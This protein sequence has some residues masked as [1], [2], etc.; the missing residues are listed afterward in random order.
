M[1][2]AKVHP[3][4]PEDGDRRKTR[5][6]FSEDV[7]GKT[8]EGKDKKLYVIR[9]QTLFAEYGGQRHPKIE[10]F[11]VHKKKGNL[12]HWR[13]VPPK[14]TTIYISHEWYVLFLFFLSLY[15][16]QDTY[17]TYQA[18]NASSGSSRHSNVSSSSHTRAVS[19]FSIFHTDT[20]IL[21]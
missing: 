14:S 19:F 10:P 20:R 4:T 12:I 3:S 17:Y 16:H 7:G 6:D 11:H 5:K 18:R 8:K 21:V 15:T 2:N 1:K 9:L 13:F